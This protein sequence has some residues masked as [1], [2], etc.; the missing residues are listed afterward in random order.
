MSKINDG[1][2]TSASGVSLPEHVGAVDAVLTEKLLI[3]YTGGAW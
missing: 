2:E 3:S 1:T